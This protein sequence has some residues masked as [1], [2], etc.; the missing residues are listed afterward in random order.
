VTKK[1]EEPE[2]LMLMASVPWPGS[3]QPLRSAS[4]RCPVSNRMREIIDLFFV[5]WGKRTAGDC[6]VAVEAGRARS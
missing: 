6:S 3:G 5:A 2:F 1:K 4:R